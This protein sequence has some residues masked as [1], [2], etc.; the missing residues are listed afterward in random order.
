MSKSEVAMIGKALSDPTRLGIYTEIAK[1]KEL[2]CGELE[3]CGEFSFATVSHHLGVL[4]R[5]GLISSRRSGQFIFYR[6]IKARL[7][8]YRRYLARLT[9]S[10]KREGRAHKGA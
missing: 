4:S 9:Q 10:G 2:F 3:A 6:A 8:E 1:R 5:A 7:S